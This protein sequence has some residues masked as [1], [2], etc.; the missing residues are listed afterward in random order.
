MI[1][2]DGVKELM[3]TGE[4]QKACFTSVLRS[5]GQRRRWALAIIHHKDDLCQCS[6][7]EGDIDELRA[8]EGVRENQ[9]DLRCKRAGFTSDDSLAASRAP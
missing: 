3:D 6:A 4:A 2:C 7:P 1:Q 9:L 8:V 5:R